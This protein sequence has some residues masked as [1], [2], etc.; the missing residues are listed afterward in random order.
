MPAV[1]FGA[2]LEVVLFESQA[3]SQPADAVWN[4]HEVPSGNTNVSNVDNGKASV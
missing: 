2:I 4:P 3:C 1:A